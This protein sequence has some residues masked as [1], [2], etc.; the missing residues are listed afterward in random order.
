[1]RMNRRVFLRGLG[2]SGRGRAI[3]SS[4]TER[5]PKGQTVT[6]PRQLIVMFTHYGC[7]T[8]RWFSVK[9]HGALAAS[10]LAP[11]HLAPLT[12]FID[13]LL[14]PRGIRAMNEWT[15]NN[16]GTNGLGQGNDA[17]LQVVGSSSPCSP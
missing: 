2:G 17:D 10:D 13:K 1:M 3:L 8:N 5:A 6:A 15:H 4:I 9:S 11:T 14:I 12:P 7:D 16:D